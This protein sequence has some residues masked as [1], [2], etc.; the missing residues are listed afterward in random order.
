MIVEREGGTENL[1]ER[2]REKE[3]EK[4]ECIYRPG[5]KGET[6]PIKQ[7]QIVKEKRQIVVRAKVCREGQAEEKRKKVRSG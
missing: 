7:K 4:T 6:G 5:D 3:M 1:E 2:G